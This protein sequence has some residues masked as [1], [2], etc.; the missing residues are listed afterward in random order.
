MAVPPHTGRR[1]LVAAVTFALIL[2]FAG[3]I[4]AW[5]VLDDDNLPPLN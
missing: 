3:L 2:A 1:T 5:I 4:T